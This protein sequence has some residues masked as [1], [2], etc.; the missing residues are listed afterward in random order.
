M[1]RAGLAGP[2]FQR[3]VLIAA[4]KWGP[5]PKGATS[6]GPGRR[7]QWYARYLPLPGSEA[8]RRLLK[9]DSDKLAGRP[10]HKAL[11]S[12]A[13]VR[14][15]GTGRV[16]IDM[17]HLR[18]QV[19]PLRSGPTSYGSL[20]VPA[21]SALSDLDQSARAASILVWLHQGLQRV[22]RRTARLRLAA[23]ACCCCRPRCRHRRRCCCCFGLPGS[24][25]V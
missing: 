6:D 19:G 1:P 14:C 25:L 13:P 15:G 9:L 5:G 21:C 7:G 22:W 20:H 24:S 8:P 23:A 11:F 17:K 10:L 18:R 12:T 16:G 3:A 2:P 4:R